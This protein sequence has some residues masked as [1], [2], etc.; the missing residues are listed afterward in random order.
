MMPRTHPPHPELA[1]GA[2][3][4]KDAG[5]FC[6]A[7]TR[8]R[9]QPFTTGGTLFCCSDATLV[10]DDART[11][12]FDL[13]RQYALRLALFVPL[14]RHRRRDQRMSQQLVGRADRR[15]G[16]ALFDVVGNLR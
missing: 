16:D 11:V 15:D 7:P 10:C 1:R 13:G 3:M 8:T 2:R 14:D 5:W 4:S 12:V 9:R 6:S